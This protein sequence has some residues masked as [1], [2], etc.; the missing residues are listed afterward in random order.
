MCW[1]RSSCG[2]CAGQPSAVCAPTQCSPHAFTRFVA[3]AS[4]TSFRDVRA[5]VP[6]VAVRLTSSTSRRFISILRSFHKWH[7]LST[8]SRRHDVVS[9]QETKDAMSAE[10]PDHNEGVPLERTKGT[11]RDDVTWR[12]TTHKTISVTIMAGKPAAGIGF[13]AMGGEMAR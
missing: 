6:T 10:L 7:H 4:T 5:S 8:A 12:S 2:R 3:T 11:K 9:A 1:C 13:L